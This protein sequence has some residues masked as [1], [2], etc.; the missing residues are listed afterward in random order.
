MNLLGSSFLREPSDD[1]EPLL[2][3]MSLL[4]E[5][6]ET[7]DSDID[8]ALILSMPSSSSRFGNLW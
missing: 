4:K 7:E 6:A 2:L 3:I 5:E 8:E 1:T